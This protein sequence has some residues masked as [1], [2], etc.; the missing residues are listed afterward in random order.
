[1]TSPIQSMLDRVVWKCGKCGK[2]KGDPSCQCWVEC[3]CGIT[4]GRF[5]KCRREWEHDAIRLAQVVRRAATCLCESRYASRKECATNRLYPNKSPCR[6]SCHR[7]DVLDAIA[8]AKEADA[9]ES[10]KNEHK[11]GEL[12]YLEPNHV[13]PH[14][15]PT[16]R[17]WE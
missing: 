9:R 7:K 14:E 10:C 5:E 11:D 15:S 13:L 2:A 8:K 4:R 6:C 12:C 16:G 1:M 3:F 17:L